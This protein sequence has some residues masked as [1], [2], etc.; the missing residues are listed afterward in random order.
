MFFLPTV[1][2]EYQE[3]DVRSMLCEGM[4]VVSNS[5]QDFG[6]WGRRVSP[7]PAIMACS[8]SHSTAHYN[9]KIDD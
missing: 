7:V 5:L 8:L 9:R 6:P 2:E 3:V 4:E 1:N